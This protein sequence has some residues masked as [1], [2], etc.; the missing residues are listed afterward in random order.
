MD[1]LFE[2]VSFFSL[3]DF[4]TV[5][6]NELV[7]NRAVVEQIAQRLVVV[8]SR[9]DIREQARDICGNEPFFVF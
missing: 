3:V 7:D 5:F 9:D 4:F 6:F 8:D 1:F 2:L